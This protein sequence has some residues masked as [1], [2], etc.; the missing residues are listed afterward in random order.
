MVRTV[1]S[2][3]VGGSASDVAGDS[4]VERIGEFI[5][6]CVSAILLVAKGKVQVSDVCIGVLVSDHIDLKD[7]TLVRQ[8]ATG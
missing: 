2:L 3:A 5:G 8:E 7:D 6:I 1:R 4:V